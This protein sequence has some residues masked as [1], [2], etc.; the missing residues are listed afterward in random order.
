M[1]RTARHVRPLLVA[2]AVMASV[3]V[4]VG[5]AAQ[6]QGP[7]AHGAVVALQ[8]TP[9]LWLADAQGVLHWGGDTRALAGRHVN[10]SDR[11]EV[12]LAHLRT[13]PVGDP[14]LSAGLLK[15]GD[16]IYLVK[17][18]TDWARPR[19]FHIQS[20]ADVELFGIN[21]SNYGAFVLDRATWEARYGMSAADLERAVLPAAVPAEP[22]PAP[23]PTLP[24]H[25]DAALV[26]D[27]AIARG[28]AADQAVQIAADVIS[29]G[30]VD[31]FLRGTDTGA[32]Y[33]VVHCQWRSPQ[34]P[35]A[36]EAPKSPRDAA[37]ALVD[38]ALMP[39][40]DL[41]N[42]EYDID[43]FALLINHLDMTVTFGPLPT[44]VDARFSYTRSG[45]PPPCIVVN[46]TNRGE[47]PR[48]LAPALAHEL[49]HALSYSVGRSPRSVRGMRHRGSHRHGHRRSG[50]GGG[51]AWTRCPA[52]IP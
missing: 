33:G 46:S 25:P 9:H 36:P 44:G 37:A 51:A 24:D 22:P 48:A 27:T 31:A 26:R 7:F 20:I 16:P 30:A 47:R 15:Y 50:M 45:S 19:L 10:W 6:A 43:I 3:F 32:L 14:W 5:P 35:L 8:G 2:L 23:T 40:L 41:A 4:A 38:P 21:G 52:H 1:T 42:A 49:F 12:S 11:T 17:W 28:A 13:L 34:C 18:E 29:R 39:A